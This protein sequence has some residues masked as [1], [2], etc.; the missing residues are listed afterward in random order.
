MV[1]CNVWGSVE[2]LTMFVFIP[3]N[4]VNKLDQNNSRKLIFEVGARS[5]Y[6]REVSSLCFILLTGKNV[7]D[8]TAFGHGTQS[9]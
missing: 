5:H 8:Q 2:C 3:W 1:I 9:S 4:S 7:Q 6:P